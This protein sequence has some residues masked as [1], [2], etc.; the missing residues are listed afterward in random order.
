MKN[1][2]ATLPV[3]LVLGCFFFLRGKKRF[4]QT[5]K[6]PNLQPDLRRA[7]APPPHWRPAHHRQ[8]LLAG[9]RAGSN[10]AC[11]DDR[12]TKAQP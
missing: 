11:Q 5:L 10:S 1:K 12:P 9:G 3:L 8:V 6:F 7:T 2:V 4:C